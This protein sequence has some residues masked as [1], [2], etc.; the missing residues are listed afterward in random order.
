MRQVPYPNL[1][2]WAPSAMT[3]RWRKKMTMRDI[4]TNRILSGFGL[5]TLYATFALSCGGG[6]SP[7]QGRNLVSLAVHPANSFVLQG[8]TVTF[9]ATASFDQ[10]PLT[11]SNF[12]AQWASSDTTLATI[13]ANGVATCLQLGG[14][15]T[16][17]AS[18]SAKSG[19]VTATATL[20]CA[21]Q[22]AEVEFNP[23]PLGFI[24]QPLLVIGCSC[25]AQ[26]TTALINNGTSTLNINSIS[27][28][29]SAFHLISS[30]CSQQLGAGQSCDIAVGWSRVPANGEVLVDDS[31]VGSPH[32][33][34]LNG[35]LQCTP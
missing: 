10:P 30:T 25:T 32:T 22:V 4:K 29:D 20:T 17:N 33:A 34:T 2:L 27:V 28:S 23:D 15:I 18:A 21:S 24:C 6:T 13:D 16:V 7:S 14:P 12:P 5:L 19:A 31:G 8:A 3:L 26:G 9:A 11:Q 1:E 35:I